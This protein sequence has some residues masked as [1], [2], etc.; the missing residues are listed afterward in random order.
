MNLSLVFL[1]D[2]T[3]F[4]FSNNFVIFAMIFYRMAQIQKHQKVKLDEHL[5]LF[6]LAQN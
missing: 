5:R 6:L 2:E 4:D 1:N 3:P